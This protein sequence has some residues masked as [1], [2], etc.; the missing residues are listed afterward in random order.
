[1]VLKT[2]GSMELLVYFKAKNGA[3]QRKK[4]I[5]IT[6]QALDI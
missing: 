2:I 6:L 4:E 1:V 5:K 3:A